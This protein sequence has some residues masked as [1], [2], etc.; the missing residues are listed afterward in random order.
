MRGYAIVFRS[1]A[2][3]LVALVLLA[4]LIVLPGCTGSSS[5]PAADQPKAS[6]EPVILNVWIMPNSPQPEADFLDVAKPFTDQNKNVSIKVT[7]LDWGSAWTKITAA[8]TSGEGPDV[9]QLG[10]TWVPAIAAMNALSQLDDKVADVGGQDAFFPASWKTTGIAGKSGVFG[11]PW[12]VDARALYYR[13][14]V[15]AKAKVDPKE[16]FKNW[17]TFEA[18]LKKIN[19]TE[20][21]G[22]KIAAIGFPG[23]NDWNVAHNVMPWVWGA[24]GSELNAD[25]TASAIN[26]PEALDGVLFYTGLAKEGLV[27]KAVLE[28]NTADAESAFAN[29]DFAVTITGPWLIKQFNT[30]QAKGGQA[31][32]VTAKNYAVSPIPEGPKGRFTFFGGSNLAIMKSSKHQK[33]A[34]DLIKFL[35]TKEAQLAYSK[36]SG[37]LPAVKALHSDP[38][39]TSDPNMAAFTEA[40]KYG[41]SYA[42][43]PAWGPVEGVLVKHFGTI[44][45]MTTG[46]AGTYNKET[47]QKELNATATEVNDL[48]KQGQ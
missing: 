17:D 41:R 23:K 48:L 1:K 22:K 38:A 7:V 42:N 30:P 34:W 16:A 12:F 14:D 43:I 26:S 13:T 36:A 21:N 4:A 11:I 5:K 25:N 9:L 24:G 45:D 28:K 18:A 31:E 32:T 20:S 29:G 8:A 15:F 10:T 46:V 33:E 39:L 35:A 44:W 3:R 47:V 6:T 40:A 19:G 2:S 37:Q 27:S